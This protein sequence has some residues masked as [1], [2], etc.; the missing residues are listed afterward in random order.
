[1]VRSLPSIY[2]VH[3]PR[4]GLPRRCRRFSCASFCA[5]TE[6]STRAH[7]NAFPRDLQRTGLRSCGD[8]LRCS[9]RTSNVRAKVNRSSEVGFPEE[10]DTTI[11][12]G[13]GVLPQTAT[14]LDPAN[15]ESLFE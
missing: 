5:D 8:I 1:M 14:R 11:S 4:L 9:D 6:H 10:L 3:T 12:V 13:H 2:R 7:E 15:H